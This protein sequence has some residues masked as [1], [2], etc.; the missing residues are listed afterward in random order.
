MLGTAP[1]QSTFAAVF[2]LH[3]GHALIACREGDRCVVEELDR[4]GQ[5]ELDFLRRVAQVAPNCRRMMVL[6]PDDEHLAFDHAYDD[7]FDR[8]SRFVEVEACAGATAS[9]LLD[10]LRVL[11]ALAAPP[12]G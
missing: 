10:R 6:G 4:E 12:G 8:S 11:E 2:W 5:A 3:H 9:E 1:A 7:L